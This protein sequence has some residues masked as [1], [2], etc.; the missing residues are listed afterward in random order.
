MKHAT[1]GD[2]ARRSSVPLEVIEAQRARRERFA[3]TVENK[4]QT[5]VRE[6]AA[7]W[8]DRGA[9]P[10]SASMTDRELCELAERR[11]EVMAQRI[12]AMP[13]TDAG[14]FRG[15]L[16]EQVKELDAARGFPEFTGDRPEAD[17]LAGM[18]ARAQCP[19][20]WRRQLRRAAVRMRELQGIEAG[21]VCATRRQLYCTTDTV[22]RRLEQ[23][24]RNR[25]ILERTELENERGQVFT[26]AELADKGV[27]NKAIRRGE[28]MTRITGCETL[29]EQAGHRGVFLTLTCPSRFHS[30]LRHG[31]RNPKWA[32]ETPREAQQWLCRTWAKA[33]A[34]LQRIGVQFYGFRVA[35]PHHDGCPHWHALLWAPAGQLWRLVLNLRRWWLKEDGDEAG[36]RAHRLKAVLMHKGGA[37]GYVAKYI[38]KNIDD[39]GAVAT[40]GHHDYEGAE[41]VPMPKQG[42]MFAGA[43]QRVEAWAA[44]WGVRQFQAIGQPP[45]TVWRELRRIKAVDGAT[46]RV[47]QAWEAAQRRGLIKADW[48][49]YVTAQG[50]LMRGRCYLIAVAKREEERAGRYET[51]T[52][53]RPMGVEDRLRP[54]EWILSDRREWRPKG[55]WTRDRQAAPKGARAA[56]TRVNN[57]TRVAGVELHGR[58]PLRT[59]AEQIAHDEAQPDQRAAMRAAW[60][61]RFK[62]P[63]HENRP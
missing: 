35:E 25:A 45:V 62:R 54:G 22:R 57:C 51:T 49:G 40:E 3:A 27:A 44:A 42:D 6:L 12:N 7:V 60:A 33:R 58:A 61:D 14:S 1:W 48:A 32:G 56:W 10:V 11:A 31:G 13:A 30:T 16:S 55:Q 17:Q 59:W 52:Q 19:L 24:A 36:A 46:D 28:L 23:Q 18:I 29:A 20:W 53:G 43:A 39:A 50:G 63:T 26:L 4:R 38:A 47:R 37:S 21:E 5:A 9:R 41:A 2:I 34:R 15:W 8:T